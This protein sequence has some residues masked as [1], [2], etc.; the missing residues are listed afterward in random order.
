M[1]VRLKQARKA[2][3]LT[4]AQAAERLL[5]TGW[6][7]TLVSKIERGQRDLYAAELYEFALIYGESLD[8]FFSDLP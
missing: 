4:Q 3:G 2:A 5:G 8:Y 6:T 1:L 7:Q